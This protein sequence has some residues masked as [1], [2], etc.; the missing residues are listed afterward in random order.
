[1]LK[2]SHFKALLARNNRLR[3]AL[4]GVADGNLCVIVPKRGGGNAHVPIIPVGSGVTSDG[5]TDKFSAA[6]A[7][8]TVIATGR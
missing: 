2:L 8:A 7:R 1:M 4:I 6:L 3:N 5:L